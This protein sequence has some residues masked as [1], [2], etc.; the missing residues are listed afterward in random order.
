MDTMEALL[1]RRSIRKYRPEPVSIEDLKEILAAG[2]T[3]PSAVN[4][5]HWYF[6][7]VQDPAALE[8]VK[9]IMGGVVEKFQPVLEERF[10]R[11]PEQIGITN[12]FLSTLGGAPVCLLVFMLKPDYPDLSLGTVY[13]NLSLFAEEGDAMSVGVFRGQE[14]FDARTEPHAHLHCA[15]CGRVIDVPLPGEPETQLCALAQ[16]VTDAQ[17]LGCSITFTGLCKTCQQADK[18][19]ASE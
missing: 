9:A 15:Q 12:R 18:G 4:M 16:S 19:S 13:R 2:A 17:V 3:A 11:H 1:T 14:R 10:S 7:A 8:E 5:Q 6:V